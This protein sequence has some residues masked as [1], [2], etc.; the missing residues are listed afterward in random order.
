MVVIEDAKRF[1]HVG[2][3]DATVPD[4]QKVFAIGGVR[5]AGEIEGA[6]VNAGGGLIEIN[7]NKL[8]MH[9]RAVATGGFGPERLWQILLQSGSPDHADGAIGFGEFQAFDG[10]IRD[11]VAEN[12]VLFL[13]C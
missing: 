6:K 10:G 3:G 13:E 11:A 8:V 1:D 7:D 5:G 4:E 12:T 9:Q 2:G